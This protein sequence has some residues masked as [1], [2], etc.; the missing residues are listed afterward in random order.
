MFQRFPNRTGLDII[1]KKRPATS[2]ALSLGCE[3]GLFAPA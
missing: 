1:I 3:T 2:Q